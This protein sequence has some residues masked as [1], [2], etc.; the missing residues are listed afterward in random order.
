MRITDPSGVRSGF[1]YG[2]QLKVV[3]VT[4]TLCIAYAGNVGAAIEAIRSAAALSRDVG[5]VELHLLAAHQRSEPKADF[6]VASLQPTR[7]VVIK[8]GKAEESAAGWLGDGDAFAQYQEHHH[9]A[10]YFGPPLE[11]YE[12]KGDAEDT[13]VAHRMGAGM[14]AAVYGPGIVREG[15]TRRVL[16]P[17]GGSHATVGEAIVNAHPRVP[18]GLFAYAEGNRAIAGTEGFGSVETG[19]FSYSLLTPVELGVGAIGLYFNEGRVGVLY[20]PLLV[21]EP[22]RYPEASVH[23]FIERVR[24]RHGLRLHGLIGE[25]G[26]V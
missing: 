25:V 17:E 12:T 7:L 9:D 22:E 11:F 2:A 1:L 23:E 6:I 18:D 4:P 26:Q 15:E 10:S 13:E 19:A 3:L 8:D 21:D 24:Q 20:A 14:S 5:A 16:I